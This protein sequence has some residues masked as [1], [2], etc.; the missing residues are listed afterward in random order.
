[1]GLWH[2]AQTMLHSTKS[3]HPLLPVPGGS[4][5]PFMHLPQVPYTPEQLTAAA[6]PGA[7]GGF[8]STATGHSPGCRS[9]PLQPKASGR[10]GPS[11]LPKEPPGGT[12]KARPQ[13]RWRHR[14]WASASSHSLAQTEPHVPLTATS[15]RPA[16]PELLLPS[17]KPV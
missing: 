15:T 8:P 7:Q 4:Q 3:L 6:F 17:R 1:M 10:S 2:L 11:P 5:K 12:V 9:L 14:T 13:P 16:H